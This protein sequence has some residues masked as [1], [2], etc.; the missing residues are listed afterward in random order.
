[1][2]VASSKFSILIVQRLAEILRLKSI[3]L[4]LLY[5]NYMFIA[6]SDSILHLHAFTILLKDASLLS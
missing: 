5:Q 6:I 3:Y 2:I 4:S 1:M